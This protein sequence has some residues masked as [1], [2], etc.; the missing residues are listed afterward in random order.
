MNN[1]RYNRLLIKLS[2]A[3]LKG[4]SNTD[5][6]DIKKLKYIAQEILAI[7]NMGIEVALVTG[8]GNIFRGNSAEYWKIERA[9]ADNV[10]MLGTIINALMLKAALEKESNYKV[11]VM[12]A[13]K[14]EA[15]AEPF[16]RSRALSHL[17]KGHLIILAAGIGQP[18]ITTDYTAAQRA[19]ELRCDAM[20]VAKHG[21]NGVF[22]SNPKDDN[23]AR[24]YCTLAYDDFL[25]NQLNIMDH[26]AV[27]LAKQHNLPIHIFNF[28]Q[29]LAAKDICLGKNIG[30]YI[31]SNTKMQFS[32]E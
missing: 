22:D 16:I 32:N 14:I 21:V 27:L 24:Q 17:D 3:A 4:D 11:R 12:S 20:L 7:K 30:T 6:F 15:V 10:G 28:D 29:K 19:L 25:I 31:S 9:E 1:L 5:N 26:S 23:N 13:I 8:G 18:F 2:G